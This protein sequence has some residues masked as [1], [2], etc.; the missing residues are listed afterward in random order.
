MFLWSA[1]AHGTFEKILDGSIRCFGQSLTRC[2]LHC[3]SKSTFALLLDALAVYRTI[4]R[5]AFVSTNQ[6]TLA[7]KSFDRLILYQIISLNLFLIS[8]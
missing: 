8:W 2:L 5:H 1:D 3:G 4:V 6:S 7:G